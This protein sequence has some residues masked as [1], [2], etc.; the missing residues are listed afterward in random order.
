VFNQREEVV[1]RS[2]VNYLAPLRPKI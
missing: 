2:I 1:M